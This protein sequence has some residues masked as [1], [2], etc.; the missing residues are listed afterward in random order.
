MPSFFKYLKGILAGWGYKNPYLR[1]YLF[2]YYDFH[3]VYVAY[4]DK[5][6]AYINGAD[7]FNTNMERVNNIANLLVIFVNYAV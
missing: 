5:F 1:K 6:Y 7:Y 3:S 4:K 2:F